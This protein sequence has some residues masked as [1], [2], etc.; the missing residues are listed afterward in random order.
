MIKY[1]SYYSPKYNPDFKLKKKDFKIIEVVLPNGTYLN[2][3]CHIY[4]NIFNIKKKIQKKFNNKLN[5]IKLIEFDNKLDN[6]I[7][8]DNEISDYLMIQNLKSN[9]IYYIEK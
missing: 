4:D 9:T 2:F 3:N 8:L 6:E 1:N 7:N 5:N